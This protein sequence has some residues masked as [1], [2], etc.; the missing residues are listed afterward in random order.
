MNVVL[1]NV[2]PY[3]PR[4]WRTVLGASMTVAEEENLSAISA[5]LQAAD[6]ASVFNL[7]VPFLP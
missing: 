1:Q 2:L 3:R 6:E 5:A 4:E 7:K